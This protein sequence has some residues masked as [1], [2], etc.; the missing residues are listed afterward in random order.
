MV[1]DSR[2]SIILV[3]KSQGESQGISY[4]LESGNPVLHADN[5][6]TLQFDNCYLT[7]QL[8]QL[9]LYLLQP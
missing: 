4:R 8:K 6:S 3:W 1:L 9:G 5:D 2:W 7:F